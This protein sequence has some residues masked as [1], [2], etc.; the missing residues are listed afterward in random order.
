MGALWLIYQYLGTPTPQALLETPPSTTI[1]LIF[2]LLAIAAFSKSAQLPFHSWLLGAMVAPT[3]VSALLHSSTMVIS[4]V[5]LILRI[6]PRL[7]GTNLSY[8]IAAIGI[9]TFMYTSVMALTQRV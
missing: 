9:F 1:L 4:G 6:A 7:A 2:A 3:P 5:Y 8:G